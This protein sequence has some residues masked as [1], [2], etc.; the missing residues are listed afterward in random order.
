MKRLIH[1]NKASSIFPQGSYRTGDCGDSSPQA[2]GA[3][4]ARCGTSSAVVSPAEVNEFCTSTHTCIKVGSPPW[5]GHTQ[6]LLCSSCQGAVWSSEV[7]NLECAEFQVILCFWEVWWPVLQQAC[8]FWGIITFLQ[9]I[10]TFNG[11]INGNFL[12][13]CLKD[14]HTEWILDFPIEK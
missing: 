6:T 2:R 7:L 10:S 3:R 11:L 12:L 4:G 9:T 14:F 8:W 13:D 1:R 5:C